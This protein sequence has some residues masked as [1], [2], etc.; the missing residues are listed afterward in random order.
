LY[1][2]PPS[3]LISQSLLALLNVRYWHKAAISG[4]GGIRFGGKADIP[5]PKLGRQNSGWTLIELDGL[6]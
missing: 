3:Q 6:A 1:L 5:S 2:P 4:A